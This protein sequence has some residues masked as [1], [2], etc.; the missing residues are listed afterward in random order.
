MGIDYTVDAL[1][2]KVKTRGTIPT[3]QS[4]YLPADFVD[5]MSDVMHQIVV[6]AIVSVREEYFV[7]FEDQVIV[8]NQAGYRIPSRAVG[9]MLRDVVLVNSAGKEI[10]IPRLDPESQKSS[11]AWLTQVPYGFKLKNDEIILIPTPAAAN[12]DSVRFYFERRPN[13]LILSAAAARIQSFTALTR[14]VVIDATPSNFTE[15]DTYDI[16]RPEPIFSS[17]DDDIAITDLTGTNMTFTDALPDDLAADQWIAL[18]GFSPIPQIPYEGGLWLVHESLCQVLE[19]MTDQPGLKNAR[20]R[21]DQMKENFLK[22]IT[23]RVH[24]SPQKVVQRGGIF[25]Y[26]RAGGRW[27]R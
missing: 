5:I 19:G 17:V 18:S 16:I 11:A 14:V 9:G 15:D 10:D 6:P 21:A 12:G 26:T 24:G 22:I 4:L 27:T 7:T 13:N 8:A 1:I 3:S 23:P 2:N 20:G 25:D